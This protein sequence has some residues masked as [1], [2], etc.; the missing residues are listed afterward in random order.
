MTQFYTTIEKKYSYKRQL[1]NNSKV[2]FQN[3]QN[4]K[5]QI[6]DDGWNQPYEDWDNNEEVLK[7]LLE[8]Q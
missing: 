7:C 2:I 6:D 8:E 3:K 5:I 4:I 1:K